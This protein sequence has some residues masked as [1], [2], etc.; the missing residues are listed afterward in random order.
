MLLSETDR[1]TVGAAVTAAE[2]GTAGEIVTI[3]ATESDAYH[4][5]ALHWAILAMLLVLA[6]LSAWP[7]AADPFY[8]LVVGRWS[9]TMPPSALLGIAL[10]LVTVAFLLV[11]VLLAWRPLRLALTPRTTK[12]RRVRRR[13]IALF[14][15]SAERR[16]SGRTGVLLY[17]SLAERRAEIVADAAIHSRVAP[18]IWGDAM[19]ALIAAVRDGRPGDGM[20]EA[21]TRIGAVLAEHFPRRADDI[22]E[23]PDRVIEL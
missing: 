19:I 5:V 13:A 3:V 1:A 12:A 23:L 15:A 8:E 4:D 10:I 2:F 20:A 22:N 9:L 11:R 17:L 16:T 6:L 7:G 18:E 14:R 21:V